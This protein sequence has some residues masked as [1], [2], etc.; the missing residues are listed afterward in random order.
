MIEAAGMGVAI[1][2][3]GVANRNRRVLKVKALSGERARS[4]IG[5]A[6]ARDLSDPL[7][8][9]LIELAKKMTKR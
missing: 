9:N 4:Q 1:L 8:E 6:V 7:R 3:E 2:P 5:I